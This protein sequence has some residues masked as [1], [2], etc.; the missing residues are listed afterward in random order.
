MSRVLRTDY[1][2]LTEAEREAI[3]AWVRNHGIKPSDV[4]IDGIR[5]DDATGEWVITIAMRN[6][7]GRQYID[8]SGLLATREERRPAKPDLPWP[9]R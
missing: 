3:H 9:T 2:D 6:A 4:P 7:E 8:H 5:F 1:L